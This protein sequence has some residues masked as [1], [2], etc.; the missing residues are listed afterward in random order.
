MNKYYYE[1]TITPTSHKDEIESFLMDYFYNGIEEKDDSLIL[2]SEDALDEIIRKTKDYVKILSKIFEKDID[3]KIEVEK[4]TNEDWI[5]NYKRSIVPIEIDEFYI[6]PSW[7]DGKKDKINIIID[8]ALA[9]GS[10]HH[11]TTKSCLEFVSK[12]VK[13]DKKVLDIGCGSGILA[14]ASAKKGAVVDLCDTD[15]LAIEQSKK[16]F[17]HNRVRFRNIWHG[18]V[19]GSKEKYDIVLANIV[20]DVLEIFSKEI[21]EK[22]EKGG[23]LI[24]SG[25]I[26][27]KVQNVLL[28]YSALK[29]IEIKKTG[30]WNSLILKKEK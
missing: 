27:K 12:Y 5:E 20:A 9:F 28:K 3:V 10:G 8:P 23:L 30:E 16:N 26:E 21:I 13:R 15:N 19:T 17:M 7:S 22:V 1:T 25:I 14:I 18:S 4:K 29:I 24:L 2:R 11:P 6:H